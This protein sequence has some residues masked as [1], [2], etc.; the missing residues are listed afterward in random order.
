M[1]YLRGNSSSQ[2]DHFQR[3]FK[4]S[5][6]YFYTPRAAPS[7]KRKSCPIHWKA[8]YPVHWKECSNRKELNCCRIIWVL[9]IYEFL[10]LFCPFPLISY[11]LPISLGYGQ[12]CQWKKRMSIES[13]NWEKV[14]QYHIPHWLWVQNSLNFRRDLYPPLLVLTTHFLGKNFDEMSRKVTSSESIATLGQSWKCPDGKI[15]AIDIWS[16]FLYIR[17]KHVKHVIRDLW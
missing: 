1:N 4:L 13:V 2:L 12:K 9:W 6:N 5:I 3:K 11:P 17:E 10:S 7:I 15:K 14:H 16:W 8:L